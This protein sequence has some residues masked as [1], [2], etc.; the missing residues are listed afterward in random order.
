MTRVA[1]IVGTR[2]EAIKMASVYKACAAADGIDPVL[3][4]TG[5]HREMLAQV[6]DVFEMT[7]DIDLNVMSGNQTLAG[8]TARLFDALDG[9]LEEVKPDV[10]LVQGDTT[11][12]M[13]GAISAFYRDIPVGHVEA[14]LRT[15]NLRAPFPEEANRL[16][17]GR[18]TT[19]HFAPT[20]GSR[21]NLLREH[22]EDSAIHVTGNTVIDSLMIEV[23]RQRADDSLRA[24]ID[25]ELQ[26]LLVD[27]GA[28]SGSRLEDTPY[29]LVTGHRRENHGQGFADICSSLAWLASKYS[30]HR[31]IYPVHLNPNVR[32]VVHEQLGDLH[33]ILLLPPVHYR[34]FVKLMNGSRLVLTDSG[35]VQEEAPSLGKPVLVMRETTERPEGVDAGTVRLVGTD[36][37]KIQSEVSRL[38]D[39]ESAYEQMA[40]RKNPYGDGHAAAR[41]VQVLAGKA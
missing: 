11:S 19:H 35:G 36:P 20:E 40:M 15:G 23:E 26:A 27:A 39:D 33:N 22:V 7:A 29:I 16:I 6:L 17:A 37:E 30:D 4:S 18:V 31:I 3:V 10:V 12:V 9:M 34:L 14:G 1:V 28:P 5:Q 8:L 21:Q 13:C 41:I 2:P 32:E 25:V 38:L 24:G